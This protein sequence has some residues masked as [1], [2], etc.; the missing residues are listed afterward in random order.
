M[1]APSIYPHIS[2]PPNTS[3]LEPEPIEETDMLPETTISKEPKSVAEIE[4]TL[5]AINSELRIYTR[6]NKI[7]Y[8]KV[9]ESTKHCHELIP[10]P[11][12]QN[13]T[14]N[15]ISVIAPDTDTELPIVLRKGTRSCT[16]HS[17]HNYI[18]F[19][20]LSSKYPAFV[21]KLD[22]SPTE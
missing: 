4:N 20:K 16:K 3:S 12:I 2:P 15:E 17:I 1:N 9:P 6:R 7:Q 8:G 22:N 13:S 19:S 11:S 18:S 10:A 5:P 21:S 14:G